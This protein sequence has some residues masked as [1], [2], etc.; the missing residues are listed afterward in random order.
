MIDGD[1]TLH[2]AADELGVHYM[3][4]YRYVRLGLLDAV[5]LGGIWHV[6]RSAIDHFRAGSERSPVRAGE[7]APWAERFEARLVDGDAQGARGVVEKAM[8]SGASLDSIYLTVLTPAMVNIGER[9]SAG[10]LEIGVE[11][12]ASAIAMRLIGQIG[13]RS[14]RPGRSRG[15]VVL[16]STVGERHVLP[17][18]LLSDLMRLEGWDVV[19]LGTD[20]PTSSLVGMLEAVPETVA[21]GLSASSTVCFDSMIETC[22]AVR[23]AVPDLL[24]VAGGRAIRGHE[25]ARSLGAH[26][27]AMTSAQMSDLI[28]AHRA[29]LAGPT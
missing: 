10:D 27:W 6:R 17:I 11:H 16:A 8:S 12:R 4:A 25:H 7:R 18:A 23:Q 26:A 13:P 3:T 21:L 28:E 14:T 19:D 2:E 15:E 29:A 1:L 20:L 5:K 9:W 22:A 24:I